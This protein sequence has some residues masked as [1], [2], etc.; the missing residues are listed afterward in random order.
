[1]D[2]L[3]AASAVQHRDVA[4]HATQEK[5]VLL[6]SSTAQP[7]GQQ[8]QAPQHLQQLQEHQDQCEVMFLPASSGCVN[9][10]SFDKSAEDAARQHSAPS[11]GG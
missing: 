6:Q 5:G 9:R 2:D 10:C 7:V 11:P 3:S 4:E 8:Q 1:M